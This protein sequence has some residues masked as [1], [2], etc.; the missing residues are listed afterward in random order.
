VGES[1]PV[2][3]VEDDPSLRLLYRVNLELEQFEVDEAA[4]L[5]EARA[6]VARRRPGVVVLDV[7]LGGVPSDALLD[8]LRAARIPVVL[9]TGTADIDLYRDRADD[10]LGKPFTPEALV[11]A[12]R[13]HARSLG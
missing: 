9:V 5:E 12:A 11:A 4:T 2:L 10:V 13:R 7:H 3:V 6:A 1:A 8:E